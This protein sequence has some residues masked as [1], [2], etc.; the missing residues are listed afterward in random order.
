MKLLVFITMLYNMVF[1]PLQFAFSI[2]FKWPFW[3]FEAITLTVLALDIYLRSKN[4]KELIRSKGRM[5]T[6]S[7][8][9]ERRLAD[10]REEHA[11]RKREVRVLNSSAPS[12]PFSHS[13]WSLT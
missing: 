1:I 3:F 11:A 9:L 2:S 13:P 12:S 8:I 4:L 10:D 5:A 6:S 7:N